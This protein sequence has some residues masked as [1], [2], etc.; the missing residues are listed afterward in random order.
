M[1]VP[2]HEVAH[3]V[4]ALF[5]H[6]AE[7]LSKIWVSLSRVPPCLHN[8]EL[9][10]EATKMIGRPLVVDEESLF[11][12]AAPIRMLFHS[13]APDKMPPSVLLFESLEGFRI[14]I[15][16]ELLQHAGPSNQSASPLPPRK[17]AD[18]D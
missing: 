1:N 16:V 18:D 8:T 11:E 17:D 15:K 7:R 2:Q 3:F 14:N 9:L 4:D 5:P 12:P 13:Q 10:M 6:A